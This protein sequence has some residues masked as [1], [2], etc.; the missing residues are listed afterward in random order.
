[1]LPQSSISE[2][3]AGLKGRS[4][5]RGEHR[6]KVGGVGKDTNAGTR[7]SPCCNTCM[8]SV[9]YGTLDSPASRSFY[10]C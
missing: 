2:E 9:E 5:S 6:A 7:R 1:M 3:I 8:A 10:G 4:W